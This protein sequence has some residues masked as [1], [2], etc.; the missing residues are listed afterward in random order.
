ME[1]RRGIAMR[2]LSVFPS[3]CLSTISGLSLSMLI[4]LL[5]PWFRRTLLNRFISKAVGYMTCFVFD[6][7][8]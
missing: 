1:Y 4:R 5:L 7:K 3:V 6:V 8:F 2:K